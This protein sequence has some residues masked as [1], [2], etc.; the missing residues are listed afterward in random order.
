[1]DEGDD[2]SD[3]FEEEDGGRGGGGGGGSMDE[4]VETGNIM[5]DAGRLIDG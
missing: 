5:A 1:M 4:F 2:V 3:G